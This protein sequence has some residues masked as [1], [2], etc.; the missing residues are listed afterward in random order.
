MLDEPFFASGIE[1]NLKEE[2]RIARG[3]RE[4]GSWS[5]LWWDE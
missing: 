4:A 1:R 3:R 5:F 2:C